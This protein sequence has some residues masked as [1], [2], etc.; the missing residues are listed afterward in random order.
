[1]K[2]LIEM[3]PIAEEPVLRFLKHE[4]AKVRSRVYTIL[5]EIGGSETMKKIRT[6]IK[7]ENDAG[8]KAAAEA[9]ME[10]VRARVMAAREAEKE[11]K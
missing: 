2:Y 6:N 9:C 7:L 5:M 8:M 3:G 10:E 1:M 11:V 4:N